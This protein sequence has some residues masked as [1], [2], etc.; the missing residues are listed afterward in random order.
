MPILLL[1]I[2]AF[3]FAGT[4]EYPWNGLAFWLLLWLPPFR[5]APHNV[6]KLGSLP[7][8]VAIVRL[9][10]RLVEQRIHPA[11]QDR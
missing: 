6:K 8:F 1:W 11:T 2:L 10:L 3:Y 9:G 4:L 5:S 7:D